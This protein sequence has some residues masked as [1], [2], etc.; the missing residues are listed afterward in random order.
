MR[1]LCM[2]H[3]PLLRRWR[4]VRHLVPM[5]ISSESFDDS[6]MVLRKLQLLLVHGLG[7]AARRQSCNEAF[8][9]CIHALCPPQLR[10]TYDMPPM[11]GGEQQMACTGQQGSTAGQAEQPCSA[12]P[13]AASGPRRASAALL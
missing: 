9:H 8:Q 3:A 6:R 5:R 12:A 10:S 4:R 7:G 13:R 1:R 2:G 11:M